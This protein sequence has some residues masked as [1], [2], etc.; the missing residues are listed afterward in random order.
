MV[1]YSDV[2]IEILNVAEDVGAIE[3]LKSMA[4][5]MK[6]RFACGGEIV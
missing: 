1:E 4:F 5:V 3:L 6:T 2:K